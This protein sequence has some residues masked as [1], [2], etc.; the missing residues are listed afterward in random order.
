MTIPD[1]IALAHARL[2]NLTAQ[3]TSANMIADAARVAQLEKEIADT[4]AT[5]AAL[6]GI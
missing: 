2:A 1:L 3:L 6:R 5:L 4:Q